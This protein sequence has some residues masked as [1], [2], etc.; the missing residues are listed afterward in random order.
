MWRVAEGRV[1]LWPLQ[2]RCQAINELIV[3]LQSPGVL[4]HVL[5]T[6]AI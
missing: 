4:S 6:R 5:S 3:Q 2:V 1:H